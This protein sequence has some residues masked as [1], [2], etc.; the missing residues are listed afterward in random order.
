[1]I[2]YPIFILQKEITMK[3][4][5]FKDYF[6]GIMLTLVTGVMPLIVRVVSLPMPPEL[7]AIYKGDTTYTDFLEYYKGWLVTIPALLIGFYLLSDFVTGGYRDFKLKTY[8][9]EPVI[10]AVLIFLLMAVLS[11]VFSKFPHTV[12]HGTIE[13]HEGIFMLLSYM[14]VFI[15]AFYYFR[16]RKHVLPVLA[17]L[18]FS[19]V[20]IGII[21]IGTLI[22]FD[23]YNVGFIED[24]VAGGGAINIEFPEWA[25]ATM[26]NPNTYGMYS[27]MLFPFL[28]LCGI[29]YRGKKWVNVMLLLAAALM[30]AGIPAS[31]SLGGLMGAGAAVAVLLV[32]QA[33]H[34][35][36]HKK[37]PSLA[38]G[39]V[40]V[41]VLTVLAGG[42]LFVPPIRTRMIGF[43]EKLITSMTMGDDRIPD[44]IIEGYTLTVTDGAD[45]AL[46]KIE[47]GENPWLSVTDREGQQ[48]APH[49]IIYDEGAADADKS[50][51]EP[52]NA[53]V[54]FIVPG[55]GSLSVYRQR[56]AMDFYVA[57]ANHTVKDNGLRLAIHED[58][59]TPVTWEGAP[60]NELEPVEAMGFK[61]RERFATMRG[62]IWSRS[63]PLM[64]KYPIIGSGP[65]TFV[66]V[67]PHH[68]ILAKL[69]FYDNPNTTV[70]KA[71]NLYIQTWITTG[72]I[73]ALALIFLFG[74]YLVRAFLSLI[75]SKGEDRFS[76]GL[77]LGLLAGIAAFCVSSMSTDSTI[78]SS[79]VFYVLLGLGYATNRW[80]VKKAEV[81]ETSTQ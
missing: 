4:I 57:F 15:T 53:T 60:V 31:N 63:F 68:D 32:T 46:T 3:N 23:F 8:L 47:F 37:R 48:V 11:S 45:T 35:V 74:N 30:F 29:S 43:T 54:Q 58:E 79:G 56:D 16:E 66:N 49:A 22:G 18:V 10:I 71:H 39:I 55:Y 9:N 44:Y 78:G 65:D 7:V 28:L 41:A 77:R 52:Y 34:T 14:V 69:R 26:Y 20:I 42:L 21:G 80:G 1:M 50:E 5:N 19:S 70:D 75:K 24:I 25:F 12:I 72:G 33:A 51:T 62:Y 73:S 13:R 59:L 38:V 2:K 6:I 36:Y 76:Y 17:G 64:L 40:S 81:S 27:S 67:F 61:G